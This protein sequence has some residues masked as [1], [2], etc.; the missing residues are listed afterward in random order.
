MAEESAG[1]ATNRYNEPVVDPTKNVQDFLYAA[2]QRQDDL[3]EAE[4]R[5]WRELANLR[6]EHTREMRRAETD[7]IN[8]IRAVDVGAVNRAAEVAA[9]QAT[10]LAAQVAVSAETLRAQVASTAAAGSAAL[11]TALEPINASIADLRK[12]QYEAQGKTAQVVDT[13]AET[14]EARGRGG[15]VA[16]WVGLGISAFVAFLTVIGLII[17]LIVTLKP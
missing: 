6:A 11:A 16:L 17:T 4:A 1:P 13:R 8:A 10:T 15:S 5:H 2:I 3:R 14:G 9:T 7:R 12:A